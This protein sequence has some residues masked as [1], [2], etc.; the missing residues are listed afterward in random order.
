LVF[1][2]SEGDELLHAFRAAKRTEL[3]DQHNCLFEDKAGDVFEI[4]M[5]DC[6]LH[7]ILRLPRGTFTPYSQGVKANVVFLQKGRPTDSVWIFDGR[8]NVASITKKDRRLSPEHFSEFEKCYG[9]DPNGLSKRRDL[10]EEGR[11]RRF[12]AEEIKRRGYSDITWL[13]DDSLE[14]SDDLPEP[15][16]LAMEA[17]SELEAVIKDLRDIVTLVEREE[18]V[19]K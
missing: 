16:E 8:S 1:F 14:D 18:G 12:S 9:S 4:L 19:T 15:H 3:D 13:K 10:G 17:V 11:F 2:Q 5:Q 6:D 7:T